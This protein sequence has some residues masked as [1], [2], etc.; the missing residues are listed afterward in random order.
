[1]ES[2]FNKT[3]KRTPRMTRKDK[4]VGRSRLEKTME[5]LGLDMSNNDNVRS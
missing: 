4:P 1:M 5:T 2:R 3:K